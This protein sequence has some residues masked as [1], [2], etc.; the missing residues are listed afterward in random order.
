LST[1]AR[2]LG[3]RRYLC[4]KK[5]RGETPPTHGSNKIEL[6][7]TSQLIWQLCDRSRDIAEIIELFE[8]AYSDNQNISNNVAETIE[9]LLAQNFLL[10]D[11][12]IK[13]LEYR[14]YVVRTLAPN[15]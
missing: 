7:Q 15:A 4:R 1:T 12:G 10:S 5:L 2:T 11:G 8:D 13:A 14:G 3:Q 6:N 9:E